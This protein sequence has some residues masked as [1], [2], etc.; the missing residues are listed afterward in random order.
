MSKSYK[1]A[2][3]LAD[4]IELQALH[5]WNEIADIIQDEFSGEMNDLVQG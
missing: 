2:G 3:L 1:S 4:E 5:L